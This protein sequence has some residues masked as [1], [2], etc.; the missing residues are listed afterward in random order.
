MAEADNS[1]TALESAARDPDGIGFIGLPYIPD[2]KA[3]AISE[4]NAPSVMPNTLTVSTEDYLLSRRLYL[5]T[6]SHPQNAWVNKFMEFV[7][8]NAGQQ[9]V[10]ENGFIAQTVKSEN[11]SVAQTTPA[12]YKQLTSGAERVFT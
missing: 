6:P 10:A 9:I 1:S 8:S 4:G 7:L 2:A 3:I 11:A 12:E 5:Y